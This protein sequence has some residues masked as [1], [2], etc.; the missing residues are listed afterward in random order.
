MTKIKLGSQVPATSKKFKTL[1]GLIMP[2]K[3]MPV[4]NNNPETRAASKRIDLNPCPMANNI[5]RDGG[6]NHEGDHG[7]Q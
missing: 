1:A 7:N 6:G 5:N 4:P 2:D 3:A